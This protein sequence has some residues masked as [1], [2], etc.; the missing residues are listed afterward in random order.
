MAL[1]NLFLGIRRVDGLN[2]GN[3]QTGTATV[4]TAAEVELR[5]MTDDGSAPTGIKR[6]DVVNAIE[7][8]KG[9][10]EQGG[11]NGAGA[12]LPVL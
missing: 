11:L 5:I 4:G 7:V 1:T 6:Q 12:N 9:F 2:P 10:I 8:L 3:V